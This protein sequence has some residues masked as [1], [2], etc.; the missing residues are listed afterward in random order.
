M[1]D[2]SN[3]LWCAD[4]TTLDLADVKEKGVHRTFP[5]V[6]Y[7]IHRSTHCVDA[8]AARPAAVVAQ[9]VVLF[10][11]VIPRSCRSPRAA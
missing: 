2:T 4:C 3:M 5:L 10:S 9:G 8:R 7:G 6:H 1:K 11:G